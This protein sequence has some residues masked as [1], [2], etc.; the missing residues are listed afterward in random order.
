MHDNWVALRIAPTC[1][2][3]SGQSLLYTYGGSTIRPAHPA[4][5]A[6]RASCTASAVLND[7]IPS[8][9]GA[10]LPTARTH[11]AAIASFS[12]KLIVAASPSEPQQTI[13]VH[14]LR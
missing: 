6:P 1:T 4:C 5:S 14:P 13:P 9:T 3:I 8:T 11:V 2:F 10:W 7:A 12:S